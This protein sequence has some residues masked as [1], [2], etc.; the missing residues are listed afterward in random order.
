MRMTVPTD[1]GDDELEYWGAFS[2]TFRIPDGSQVISADW[3]VRGE[4]TITYLI[5]GRRP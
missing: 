2:N 1:A 3:S 5:P 4:V